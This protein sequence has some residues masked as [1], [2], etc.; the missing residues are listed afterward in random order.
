[1][2]SRILEDKDTKVLAFVLVLK[3]MFFIT[4][5]MIYT[6]TRLLEILLPSKV[7]IFMWSIFLLGRPKFVIFK[8]IVMPSRSIKSQALAVSLYTILMQFT[9]N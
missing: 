4:Q 5:I 9:V 8:L 3:N 6:K 2:L 7:C 1:M